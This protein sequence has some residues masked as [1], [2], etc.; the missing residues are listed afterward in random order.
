MWDFCYSDNFLIKFEI[1]LKQKM[2]KLYGLGI[3]G[4]V[5]IKQG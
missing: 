1:I 3:H 2:L 5:Y 4:T